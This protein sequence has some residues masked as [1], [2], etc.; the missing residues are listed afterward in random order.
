MILL[1]RRMGWSVS[2]FTRLWDQTS[3]STCGSDETNSMLSPLTHLSTNH[4]PLSIIFAST[5]HIPSILKM[6]PKCPSLKIVV[7]IDPLT[8]A[9][10][11][12]L[13]QWANSVNLELL[14]M[15]ELEKWG[16][17]EGVRCDPGPVKGVAGEHELDRDRIMTISYTSGTTGALARTRV[18][19]CVD[20]GSN[21]RSQGRRT[22]QLQSHNGGNIE[23]FWDCTRR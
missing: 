22:H 16:T 2:V 17:D 19:G 15:L 8:R 5:N 13:S 6:A 14:D 12:V 9:E 23:F 7:A 20:D 1:V 3:H 10:R 11:D 4:C 21:R 18:L